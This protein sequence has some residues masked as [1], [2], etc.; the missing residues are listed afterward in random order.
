MPKTKTQPRA[1]RSTRSSVRGIPFEVVT[2]RQRRL[3]VPHRSRMCRQ[4]NGATIPRPVPGDLG[5]HR[6]REG[7]QDPWQDP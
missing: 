2:S 3:H 4:A 1:S 7:V 5:R 6:P